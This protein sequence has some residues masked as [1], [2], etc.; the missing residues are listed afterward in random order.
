[1]KRIIKVIAFALCIAMLGVTLCSCQYLEDKKNNRAVFTDDSK[2]AIEFRGNTYKKI[3]LPKDVSVLFGS[4]SS[5]E[6]YVTTK[7]VPVLLSS[8]YGQ[9]FAYNTKEENPLIIQCYKEIDYNFET[10]GVN[11]FLSNSYSKYSA[12]GLQDS[13]KCYVR[14]DRYEELSKELENPNLDHYYYY[15][16]S[17][18]NGELDIGDYSYYSN[19]GEFYSPVYEY[20]LINEELTNAINDTFKN[21]KKVDYKKLKD[22]GWSTFWL[23]YCDQNLLL[24]SDSNSLDIFYDS[25]D[26]KYYLMPFNSSFGIAVQMI[27]V[28][29]KYSKLFDQLFSEQSDEVVK[30]N[31]LYQYFEMDEM[32]EYAFGEGNSGEIEI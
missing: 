10:N 7:D 3:K 5:Q 12:F 4:E 13:E 18:E 9:H 17:Y 31:S 26:K 24:T 29:D 1:M 6:S 19:S 8:M 2:E 21:G 23:D 32:D 16:Y 27:L 25:A 22:E 15:D 20:K 14:E 28:P 11:Q 30:D